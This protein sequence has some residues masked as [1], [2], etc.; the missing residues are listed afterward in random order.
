[1]RTEFTAGDF[2][3]W[4]EEIMSVWDYKE[5]PVVSETYVLQDEDKTL[6]ERYEDEDADMADYFPKRILVDGVEFLS[7]GLQWDMSHPF[8]Q[9]K[10]G[11]YP[12]KLYELIW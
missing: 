11:Y 1:M 4:S 5:E 7:T 6:D 2:E 9:Y 10:N 12:D 8:V 3:G